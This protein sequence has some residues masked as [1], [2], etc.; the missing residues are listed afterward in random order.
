MNTVLK[1]VIAAFM[2]IVMSVGCF[3]TTAFAAAVNAADISIETARKIAE[4]II[5]S[6]YDYSGLEQ[7]ER[8]AL[9]TGVKT[10][11]KFIKNNLPKV[12]NILKKYGGIVVE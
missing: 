11:L 3:A 12:L 2:A 7:Q 10:V 8:G 6:E 5:N 9:S 4:E 1:K